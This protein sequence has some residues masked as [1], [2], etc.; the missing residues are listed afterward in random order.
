[1]KNWYY[2]NVVWY[3]LCIVSYIIIY[4][5]FSSFGGNLQF[6]GL[7]VFVVLT[8]CVESASGQCAWVPQRNSSHE[9]EDLEMRE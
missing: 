8:F 3:I 6:M 9:L 1:M 4:Q 2:I 7:L 5:A